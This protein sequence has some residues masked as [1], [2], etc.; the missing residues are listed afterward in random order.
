MPVTR[1]P[2]RRRKRR[3][4]RARIAGEVGVRPLVIG[5]RGSR[6][7]LWQA[8]W[9]RAR[10]ERAGAAVRIEIIRTSGDR[11]LDRPL[12]AMGGKGV[13]VKEIEEA[14]LSCAVDLAAH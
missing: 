3:S 7:A 10:L 4:P 1:A 5:S 13:F 11:F 6:L 8:E 14:L 2:S 9:T 12:A